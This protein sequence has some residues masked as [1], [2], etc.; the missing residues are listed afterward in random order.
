MPLWSDGATKE[1]WLALP[2]GARIDIKAD[3]D[4]QLPPGTVTI[5]TF[6]VDGR[7]I[8]TR[9]FVRLLDGQWSGYTYEW[10]SAGTE[11]NLLEEG[12]QARMVGDRR[13]HIPSRAECMQ[14]HT[15]AAGGSLGL[16]VAQL[17][18]DALSSSGKMENQL[19]EWADHGLFT[20]PLPAPPAELPALP[21]A[22]DQ[23]RPIEHRA[24]AYLHANCAGCHRPE[25]DNSGSVDLRFSTALAATKSCDQP[26]VKGNMGL[27]ASVRILAPGNPDLSMLVHRMK[28]EGAGR[29]PEVGSLSVDRAAVDLLS[30]WIRSL[31]ACP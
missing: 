23:S 1:R 11:A 20:A 17:N 5:K 4:F 30:E 6:S 18:G 7:R 16:E 26:P 15:D 10:N 22:D 24:R 27:G 3:G 12:S 31:A 13:Y 19:T 28:L 21:R 8:E 29:M 2:D 14:C 9:F 25:L